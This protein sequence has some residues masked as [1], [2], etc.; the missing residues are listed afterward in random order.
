MHIW[1]M[2][3]G[4]TE[5]DMMRMD[6]LLQSKTEV[7]AMAGSRRELPALFYSYNNGL[8]SIY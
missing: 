3:P 6:R 8:Y 4:G 2:S 7:G 5:V 1:V